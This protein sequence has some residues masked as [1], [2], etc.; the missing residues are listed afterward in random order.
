MKNTM[1]QMPNWNDLEYFQ[2][3]ALDNV[4]DKI[5][6]ILSGDFMFKDH[7]LDIQGY[8]ALVH[9]ELEMLDLEQAVGNAATGGIGHDKQQAG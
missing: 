3:Q 9:R 7:W 2:A 5:C 6:R 1:R 4:V 8:A